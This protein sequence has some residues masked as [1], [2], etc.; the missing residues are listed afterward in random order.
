MALLNQTFDPSTVA[1]DERDFPLMPDGWYI[2]QITE[3]DLVA[4]KT[5]NG[6]MLKLTVEVLEGDC[7]GRKVWDQLNIVNGNAQ[8]QEIAQR[9]LKKICLAVGHVG[10]LSN[11]DD[12][13]FKPVRVRI[14]TK[15]AQ[16]EYRAQNVVKGYE[17][18]S[19]AAPSHGPASQPQAQQSEPQRAAA[20]GGSRPWNR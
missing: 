9:T 4:T 15:P 3:N 11:G 10:V 18:L 14:A 2:G 12:L 6:Q 17:P 8:A 20:G 19:G 16:G 7:R 13:Q 5:G 1:D